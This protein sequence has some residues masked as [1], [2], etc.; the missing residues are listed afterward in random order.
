MKSDT[1]ASP[2][3]FS[4]LPLFVFLFFYLGLSILTGDFYAIPMPV[5]FLVASAFAILQNRTRTISEKI[6]LFAKGMGE[7]NIM[8]MCLVFILAGIFSAIAK[9]MGAIDAAVIL[10]RTLI[11]E[12]LILLG[13]FSA[14]CFIS[15]AIGTS[16][17]TIATVT[18]FALGLSSATGIS[19]EW[20]LGAVIGG[21][22]FG[23]NM[24]II[25]DTTI[26]ATRTQGVQM[27]DKFLANFRFTLPA[28]FVTIAIYLFLSPQAST[29]TP[30]RALTCKDIIL[31]LPYVMILVLSLLRMNVMVLLFSG[32]LLSLLIGYGTGQFEGWGALTKMGEGALN[33]SETLIVALLA[34]GM[35]ALIRANGGIA[36]IIATIEKRIRTSR[37]CE[38]SIAFLV[39][40]VNMFTANNTVAI[41]ISGPVA[42]ELS[43]KYQCEPRRIAAILDAASCVI[44]G[45]LP[46]GAQILIAT[47]IAKTFFDGAEA[48]SLNNFSLFTL[49]GKMY[50]QYIL[51]MTLLFFMIIKPKR[52]R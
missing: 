1:P 22:M 13:I 11:P 43:D 38:I 24:S 25:S 19:V 31:I 17:G 23:D 3:F 15:I 52:V 39:A 32:S 46:Y 8:I 34:G 35:M 44:Q 36:T 29:A 26:A 51:G 41:V 7:P 27:R 28:L 49:M 14:S 2:S 9:A 10:A 33:M 30:L 47:G 16:C 21:A 48:A 18:P 4:L 45:L 50:Y 6:D 42:K 12:N 40:L 5:A 37:A 20:M